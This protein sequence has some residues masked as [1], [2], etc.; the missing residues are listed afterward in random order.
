MQTII[1]TFIYLMAL[2]IVWN[3]KK[4][5]TGKPELWGYII[6]GP[7]I[8]H[9]PQ[10]FLKKIIDIIFIYLLAP[11]ILQNFKKILNANPDFRFMR[12]CHFRAENTL[13]CPEQNFLVENII[14]FIYLPT[15]FI[16]Q[17]LKKILAMDPELRGCTIFGPKMVHLPQTKTFLENY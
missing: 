9:L 3:F 15:L 12:M 5:L 6:L 7:Q 10:F 13:I 4:I 1:I 8:V 17:N 2:F 16:G 14:T 11:F